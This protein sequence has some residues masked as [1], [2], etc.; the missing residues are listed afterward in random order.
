MAFGYQSQAQSVYSIA[1][2]YQATASGAHSFAAVWGANAS[3]NR[4]VALGGSASASGINSIAVN[5][6]IAGGENSLA[7]G[8]LSQTTTLNSSA[9][10]LGSYT[11]LDA[12]QSLGQYIPVGYC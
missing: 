6:G 1:L 5:R 9:F 10:G 8:E 7:Q 4:S 12:Q 3:G 11:N 2:G